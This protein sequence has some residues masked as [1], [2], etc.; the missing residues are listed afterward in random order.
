MKRK[1]NLKQNLRKME[2]AGQGLSGAKVSDNPKIA[3]LELQ[4]LGIAA[5]VK[6]EGIQ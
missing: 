1:S 5:R 3:S 6:K 2:K 4:M